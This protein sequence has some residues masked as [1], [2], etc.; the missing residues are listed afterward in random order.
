MLAAFYPWVMALGIVTYSYWHC[1]G[2]IEM[3]ILLRWYKYSFLSNLEDS[4]LHLPFLASLTVFLLLLI[5][6]FLNLKYRGCIGCTSIRDAWHMVICSVFKTT[7]W[8][9]LSCL[10]TEGCEARHWNMTDLP[11]APPSKKTDVSGQ[12]AMNWQQLLS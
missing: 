5:W 7:N 2:F 6:C 1:S 9:Y 4:I 11:S 12:E 3:T 10:F 8:V